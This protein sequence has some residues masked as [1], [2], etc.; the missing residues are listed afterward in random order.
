MLGGKS[1]NGASVDI[2]SCGII[3]FAMVC[4]Y[5]PFEDA[6][7]N[8]LYKKI[9]AGQI[10]YPS[11][12]SPQFVDLMQKLLEINPDKRISIEDLEEHPWFK[13]AECILPTHGIKVGSQPI[14][15]D[16]KVLKEMQEIG[17]DVNHARM[18]V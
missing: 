10:Y 8:K 11:R 4:G 18:S 9:L 7:T 5:L 17:F 12:V 13:L 2:W 3:L 1:Y 6:D 16:S 15:A 14:K